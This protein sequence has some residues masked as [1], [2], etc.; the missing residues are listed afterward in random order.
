MLPRLKWNSPTILWLDYDAKLTRSVLSDIAI[1]ISS[2]VAGSVLLVTVNVEPD[3]PMKRRNRFSGIEKFRMQQLTKD[4]GEERVP[5][6][7]TGKNLSEWSKAKVCR[8]II[9]NEIGSTL[10]VVNGGREPMKELLFKQIFHFNY[11]DGAKMLTV[12]GLLYEKHQTNIVERCGFDKLTFCRSSEEPYLIETPHLTYRE[13]RHLDTLLPP[14][15][16]EELE[17]EIAIPV[18]IWTNIRKSTDTSRCLPRPKSDAMDDKGRK[19]AAESEQDGPL[20][21]Q[22]KQ[23]EFGEEEWLRAAASNPVFDFLEDPVEDIYSLADG[24]PLLN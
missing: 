22:P 2:A 6:G 18:L 9:I 10:N 4:V 7:V 13:L 11:A 12:G 21:S 14:G 24:K 20:Q 5:L 8:Q 23:H 15:V 1:F 19:R 16:S 17:C 3:K